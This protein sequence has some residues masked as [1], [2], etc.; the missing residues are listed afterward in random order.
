MLTPSSCLQL[1]ACIADVDTVCCPP[2]PPSSCD[3]GGAGGEGRGDGKTS[4]VQINGKGK[5]TWSSGEVYEGDWHQGLQHGRGTMRWLDRRTY[6]GDWSAGKPNGSGLM[7]YPDGRR[8][9]GQW[10]MG[11]YLG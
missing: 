2:R 4:K 10:G 1:K 8:E 5:M 11:V 7:L 6:I 3:G 9:Q